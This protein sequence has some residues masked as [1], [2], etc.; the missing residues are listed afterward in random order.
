MADVAEIRREKVLSRCGLGWQSHWRWTCPD[1]GQR[2]CNWNRDGAEQGF[3]T[4]ACKTGAK[5]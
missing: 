3:L 2:G 1:C 5:G 4:H